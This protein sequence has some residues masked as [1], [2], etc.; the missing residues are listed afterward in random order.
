MHEDW[1]VKVVCDA[2][3]RHSVATCSHCKYYISSRGSSFMRCLIVVQDEGWAVLRSLTNNT[4]DMNQIAR[5]RVYI[6]LLPTYTSIIFSSCLEHTSS[7][8]T[9]PQQPELSQHH[10]TCTKQCLSFQNTP[11]NLHHFVR[12]LWTFFR[13]VELNHNANA[14]DVD[15]FSTHSDGSKGQQ[16][17]KGECNC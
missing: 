14:S 7:N 9:H 13:D 17:K 5:T 15:S 3:A 10:V 4:Q 6:S 1:A 12:S 2:K 11:D 8:W 16:Q